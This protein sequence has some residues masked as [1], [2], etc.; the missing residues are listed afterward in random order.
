M[1]IEED[2]TSEV[3]LERLVWQNYPSHWEIGKSG[4]QLFTSGQTDFWQKTHYGFQVDNGHI[5]SAS[6]TG[7]FE[8]E[9]QVY[10]SFVHQYD[11]AGL[12]I[13][14]DQ[15]HWIKTAIEAEPENFNHLGAV[16]TSGGYSDWSTQNLE[17]DIS[18]IQLK[19][20]RQ[21][22]DFLVFWKLPEEASWNQLRMCHLDCPQTIQAGIYACSPREAGFQANFK[23]LKLRNL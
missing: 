20:T 16:V 22:N 8:M 7:D 23:F 17:K 11:Q 15:H 14:S 4:L 12:M 19:M 18:E 1:N 5:L 3:F 6:V 10:S 9:T 13:R 21:G 2:F